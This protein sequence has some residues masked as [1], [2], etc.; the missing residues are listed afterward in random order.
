MLECPPPIRLNP[1]RSLALIAR[2]LVALPLALALTAS[3]CSAQP[4]AGQAD[5][6]HPLAGVEINIPPAPAQG[7]VD[8]PRYPSISPDGSTIAFSWRGDLWRAPAAGGPAV[9]LTAHPG[10]D[11]ASAW[12]PDGQHIAFNSDRTGYLNLFTMNADG[13]AVQQITAE[14]RS[15]FLHDWAAAPEGQDAAE[16]G[17]LTVASFYEPDVHKEPRPYRIDP[18]GGP[19]IRLHDAFGRQPAVSPDGRYIAFVRGRASWDRPFLTNSDNRD[20]WLYDR[21]EDSFRRLTTNP[22][23][24]GKPK[25]LDADTI[26]YQSARPPARINLYTL[27]LDDASDDDAKPLTAFAD[28]VRQFDVAQDGSAA[29]V[30]VWDTLYTLDLRAE[31]AQPVAITLTASTDVDDL[32]LVK[33]LPGDADEATISPDG[34]VMAVSVH[35]EIYVRTLDSKNPPQRVTRSAARDQQL[36]W[37]PDGLTLYFVSDQDGTQSIYAATVELTRSDIEAAIAPDEDEL[38]GAEN[39]R[40]DLSPP[41]EQAADNDPEKT[42]EDLPDPARWHDAIRFTTTPIIQTAHH[43]SDPTPSPDG[44]TLAFRRGNGDL[45]L[46]DLETREERLFFAAWD[47]G[48]HWVW[49][50]DS[51]H[52]AISTE[53]QDHN[54]DL[55]LGPV[56]G[57]APMVNVSKHPAFDGLPS[58]SADGK[59]LTFISYRNDDQGDI[60][61]LY[62]DPDLETYTDQQ[63]ADYYKQA[64]EAAKKLKPLPVP[65][66]EPAEES[67]DEPEAAEE[68]DPTDGTDASDD[69]G[70][71][72]AEEDEAENADADAE[73]QA[74]P[75]EPPAPLDLEDA[76][77][78]IRRITTSSDTEWN[79]R[80]LPGG[81]RILFSRG[82]ALYSVGW[83]GKD[84]KKLADG[85]SPANLTPNG[86]LLAAV[87]S[88]N[89]LS[90]TTDSGKATA[91][92]LAGSIRVDRLD[93]NRQRFA[94]SARALSTMFYD[95]TYKGMDW[96]TIT[97][98]YA[99]L[100]QRA[101]TTDEFNDVANQYLGLLDASHMGIRAP[102]RRATNSQPNGYLGGRY[103]RVA[104][105]YKVAHIEPQTPAAQGPMRLHIGDII[106]AIDFEPIAPG[107]TVPARLVGRA[108][109]ETAITVMR[110][111][112][113]K[114][115]EPQELILLLTPIS[116]AALDDLAYDN[117]Q[118]N[119]KRLVAEWSDG[120][121]GYIHIQSMNASS[122]AEFERDLYAACAD[123][124]GM[125]I[126]VRD[127]GGGWTTDRLLGSIMTRRHAYTVP[128]GA[129]PTRTNSY[130]NDR[131]F[132]ARYNLPMNA[133]CN[134][135]SFSNAEIFSHAFKTLGR[136]TL[137]GQTTA[138][139]VI[140]TGS[141]RLLDGT[142]I[143]IPF[144]GWYL[145]DGT[146]MENHGAIPD[147]IVPQTPEA[148]AT[149]ADPQ[150][151]AAVADLL[152]RIEE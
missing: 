149:G 2:C 7:S 62:L 109:H 93:D 8:L 83:D 147:L 118:L 80:V 132:I 137:V 79:A 60:Y 48:T 112:D 75:A 90:L 122:L 14:D 77:L 146:D 106:T 150:L 72:E 82:G 123:K 87:K 141:H 25:W 20:L 73:D 16:A 56:D 129:D 27:D 81:G 5:P 127:N 88:G 26:I 47:Q 35:G 57:S 110:A 43:D 30:Q 10:D 107:D 21:K 134:Q 117:W 45:M 17:Y 55:W 9:R 23:N 52:L 49:S 103:E 4:E 74:E 1:P 59:I 64:A 84:E 89:A 120:K 78:R 139:G 61:A 50:H 111:D 104:D 100:A 125:V 119:N 116:Y 101:W 86:G 76:Y 28:D 33:T 130:P 97:A 92:P 54:A 44:E 66:A 38:D 98:K 99:A 91:A 41:A 144:R 138:G 36:A 152:K 115:G 126:D 37:S 53:D 11:L 40:G 13:T 63:L 67:K 148:E 46:L 113:D 124:L 24:D 39:G 15:I 6:P 69:E 102:D 22:G 65:G 128:R 94:E 3:A 131:L 143:R 108:G 70:D 140:S 136:G 151:Q 51:R 142:T 133:L 105:G 114:Q 58:F 29:V 31:D 95:P 71:T 85:V 145:P 135:N 34:K 19:I 18:A 32:V 68:G 42:D 121:L 12:S 96:D